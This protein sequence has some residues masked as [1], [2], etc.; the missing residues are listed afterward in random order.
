MIAT[1]YFSSVRELNELIEMSFSSRYASSFYSKHF[2]LYSDSN[3]DEQYILHR[4]NS[5]VRNSTY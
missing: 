1:I 2:E 5:C 3:R 4:K